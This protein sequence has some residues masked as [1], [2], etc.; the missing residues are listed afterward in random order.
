V[1][2]WY[3]G[4]GAS[5]KLDIAWFQ[6]RGIPLD[7]RNCPITIFTGSI[8]GRT[9]AVDR[10]SLNNVDYVRIQIGTLNV[11]LVPFVVPNVNI[12]AS[13]FD[14]EITREIPRGRPQAEPTQ[15]LVEQSD[16]NRPDVPRNTSM[17]HTPKRSIIESSGNGGRGGNH[18]APGGFMRDARRTYQ[19][20]N[21]V[22]RQEHPQQNAVPKDNRGKREA[23]EFAV[24][25]DSDDEEEYSLA[26]R[27]G[28]WVME[29]LLS[30]L[31]LLV[32]LELLLL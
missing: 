7:N 19:V 2:H 10:H 1:N 12:G 31:H 11:A 3:P 15:V 32:Q 18:S 8:V 27:P 9:L 28:C 30:R 6:V 26:E 29:T 23:V 20:T 24:R 4:Y 17:G 5:G 25:E 13:F 22:Y 14:L 16:Q 21:P